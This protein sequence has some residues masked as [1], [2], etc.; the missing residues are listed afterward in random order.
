MATF[1]PSEV[2]R[3]KAKKKKLLQTQRQHSAFRASEHCS[4]ELRRIGL[5]EAGRGDGS[6]HA[7]G[8]TRGGLADGLVGDGVA[9]GATRHCFRA[10][11]RLRGARRKRNQAPQEQGDEHRARHG[12]C[13]KSK[14]G[15]RDVEES[16]K[17]KD[18]RLSQR[19]LIS[20]PCDDNNGADLTDCG[21][22]VARSAN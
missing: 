10:R 16:N 7:P 2:K 15:T 8:A 13:R 11:S 20:R 5:G 21:L 1:S 19:V 17:K 22:T 4:G 18:L 9:G 14:W 3:G 6:G 12:G